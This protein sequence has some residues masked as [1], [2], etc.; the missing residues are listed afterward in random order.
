VGSPMDREIIC[1]SLFGVKFM[2]STML[3]MGLKV[4]LDMS[5]APTVHDLSGSTIFLLIF[6]SGFT[7]NLVQKHSFRKAKLFRVQSW[8]TP[9][10]Q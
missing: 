8:W 6:I 3:R 1:F 2:V 4:F 10:S 9:I 7:T 5:E